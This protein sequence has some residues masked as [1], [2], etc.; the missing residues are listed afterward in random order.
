[1][2]DMKRNFTKGKMNKDLDERLI[3]QGEYRDATNIQVSTSEDSE[4]GTVQNILGNVPGC[5]YP[6]PNFPNPIPEGASTVGSVSDEKNDSLYW[7][8]S[9]L[10][11]PTSYIPLHA[12]TE[13]I[14][15]K[16]MIMRTN[17]STNSGCEPV[18]VDKYGFIVNNP[19]VEGGTDSNFITGLDVFYSDIT[20]G[21]TV[22][23]Y[24]NT[25]NNVF[26]NVQIT[27]IGSIT[28]IPITYMIGTDTVVTAPISQSS[29]H[30]MSIRSFNTNIP[31]AGNP[32]AQN[33][34]P[35]QYVYDIVTPPAAGLPFNN[36][37]NL[38][39]YKQIQ[40]IHDHVNNPGQLGP[41]FQVGSNIQ[42]TG[43]VLALSTIVDISIMSLC[44]NLQPGVGSGS[45]GVF[46]VIT[47]QMPMFGP[48]LNQNL[49][50]PFLPGFPG[51]TASYQSF[52]ANDIQV[53]YDP[54]DISTPNNVVNVMPISQQWT[55]DIYNILYNEDGSSTGNILQISPTIDWPSGGCI[56]PT[57]VTS[58]D[59]DQF[60][61]VDC[62]DFSTPVA[63]FKGNHANSPG[64][65][66]AILLPAS[67]LTTM[68]LVESVFFK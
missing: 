49:L 32:L 50:Q 36:Q 46:T 14:S 54:A 25:G 55:N 40:L 65:K 51:E 47:I 48:S 42:I 18:F 30:P 44:S 19:D 10:S 17:I 27:N 66:S 62:N 38:P 16:D 22:T 8:V 9:G 59:D 28:T 26:D 61:I 13:S 64:P 60:E 33:P 63:P 7:L 57:T 34:N 21:M 2:P 39:G 5:T 15:L 53:S 68:I 52:D 29:P 41:G 1:M 24:D 37:Q 31:F 12:G 45:C 11:D 35:D 23:G 56:D 6:D 3:P 43:G 67:F 20:V 4:V 58:P